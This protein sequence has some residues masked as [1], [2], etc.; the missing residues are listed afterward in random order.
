MIKAAFPYSSSLHSS[1]LGAHLRFGGKKKKKSV[2]LLIKF[3][4][5]F[6]SA[7]LKQSEHLQSGGSEKIPY[8]SKLVGL[9]FL[10]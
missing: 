1:L 8:M 10:C 6:L 2:L 7:T 4:L 9:P 3:I 5:Q